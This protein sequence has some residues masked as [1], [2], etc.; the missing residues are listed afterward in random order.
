VNHG[1]SAE[2]G[3]ELSV[4]VAAQTTPLS[5]YNITHE[6]PTSPRTQAQRTM[7]SSSQHGEG[8]EIESHMDGDFEYSAR[9]MRTPIHGKLTRYALMIMTR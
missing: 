4:F 3:F 6:H 1:H 7:Y 2:C 8:P 9:G 5:S